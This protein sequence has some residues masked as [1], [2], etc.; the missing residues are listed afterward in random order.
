MKEVHF[1]HFQFMGA[2]YSIRADLYTA[3]LKT[4][5]RDDCVPDL[6]TWPVRQLKRKPRA[7]D[8]KI[9]PDRRRM[10]E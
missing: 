4:I 8:R 3:L 6:D 9:E 7:S 2:A 1:E 10:A 5:E